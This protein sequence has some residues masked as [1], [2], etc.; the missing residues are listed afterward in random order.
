MKIPRLSLEDKLPATANA[1]GLLPTFPT[2][3]MNKFSPRLDKNIDVNSSP[4]SP[5]SQIP[6]LY[7][8]Q[9]SGPWTRLG[10]SA[11]EECLQRLME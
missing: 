2:E 3:E 11:L 5:D 6:E 1:D 9:E 8:W 7:L 4:P 10:S